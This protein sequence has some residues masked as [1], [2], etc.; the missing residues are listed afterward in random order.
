MAASH[1]Y[2]ESLQE[3][4]AL[5][6]ERSRLRGGKRD[7]DFGLLELQ[8]AVVNLRAPFTDLTERLERAFPVRLHPV[9]QGSAGQALLL[10]HAKPRTRVP[11]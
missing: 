2:N 5:K 11:R 6:A 7:L 10:D 3:A 8:P 4:R 1:T 9:L